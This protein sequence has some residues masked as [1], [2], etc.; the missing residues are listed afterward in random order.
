MYSPPWPS[1]YPMKLYYSDPISQMRKPRLRHQVPCCQRSQVI[2]FTYFLQEDLN[3]SV[4]LVK[5]RGPSN[6]LYIQ[7]IK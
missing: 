3:T 2:M 5:P 1:K 7:D 6:C 4:I